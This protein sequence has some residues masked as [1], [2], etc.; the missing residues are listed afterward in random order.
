MAGLA[1]QL[2]LLLKELPTLLLL[3]D[4][5][6]YVFGIL[7]F[8][9]IAVRGFRG[10]LHPAAH[11]GLRILLG[12]VSVVG[13]M[14]MTSLFSFL[15]SG[16]YGLLNLDT[17]AGSLLSSLIL[18]GGLYL[19]SFRLI[20]VPSLKKRIRRMEERIKRGQAVAAEKRGWKDPVKVIGILI[21]AGLVGF[22]LLQFKGFP[23][24]SEE[25]LS[26]IGISPGDLE[27][28]KALGGGTQGCAAA[29]T[30]L[31]SLGNFDNLPPVTDTGQKS[32]F[33]REAHSRVTDMRKAFVEG[34][35]YTV[36]LTEGQQ[37]CYSKQSQFC[38]CVDVSQFSSA[39]EGG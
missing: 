28:L 19:V 27:G 15:S 13:G 4:V 26:S 1:E 12:M 23:R 6:F 2:P 37:I 5:V 17:L 10:Y 20:D 3:S 16:A 36:A 14:A 34:E 38:D 7:F 39:P 18:A 8:G 21:I 11:F 24:P 32:I 25:L 22:S 35:D 29:L 9:S 33:E 30:L 31:Q